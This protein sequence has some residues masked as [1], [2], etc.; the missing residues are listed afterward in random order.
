M[1]TKL[2]PTGCSARKQRPD[3]PPGAVTPDECR[4]FSTVRLEHVT[5]GT[6]FYE[7]N[8]LG[9]VG[10]F[11]QGSGRQAKLGKNALGV[12]A[13]VFE[14]GAIGAAA[15]DIVAFAPQTILSVA[16]AGADILEQDAAILTSGADPC[17]FA[18][19]VTH[20]LDQAGE[21]VLAKRMG[22]ANLDVMPLLRKAQIERREIS[23]VT[24]P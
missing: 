23:G 10:E 12:T 4:R 20:A 14:A 9:G 1:R 16:A 8:G 24:Y 18:L 13:I 5:G 15:D 6:A 2:R 7:T 3:I 19:P 17:E 21:R 11:E 22:D